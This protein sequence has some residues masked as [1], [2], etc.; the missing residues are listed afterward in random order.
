R[1]YPQ[2]MGINA[3]RAI[4]GFLYDLSGDTRFRMPSRIA[5]LI[6]DATIDMLPSLGSRETDLADED[7]DLAQTAAAI[8]GALAY[9]GALYCGRLQIVEAGGQVLWRVLS[10]ARSRGLVKLERD[11]RTY[12]EQAFDGATRSGLPHATELLGE[13]KKHGEAKSTRHLVIP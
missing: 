8:G 11:A 12:F 6:S 5:E 4:V 10:Y 9:D 7:L 3:R 1:S 2:E 13:F